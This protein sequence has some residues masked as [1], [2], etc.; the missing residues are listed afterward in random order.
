MSETGQIILALC[1]LILLIALA[2]RINAWRI[3][4]AYAFIIKDLEQKGAVDPSSAV[5]LPYAEMGMFRM[6][7]RDFRPKALEHL[8]IGDVVGK[9]DSG[10]YYLKDKK[11]G[12]LESE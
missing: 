1:I 6:G 5:A 7:T 8:I 4:R 9:T 11:A 12:P 2:R 3:K 10:N